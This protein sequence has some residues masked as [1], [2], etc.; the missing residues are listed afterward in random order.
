MHAQCKVIIHSLV[1]VLVAGLAGYL[2][3]EDF[4]AKVLLRFYRYKQV[5]E[6][7]SS[8]QRSFANTFIVYSSDFLLSSLSFGG[9][10]YPVAQSQITTPVLPLIWC[11]IH[12]SYFSFRGLIAM[13]TGGSD[14]AATS[15]SSEQFAFPMFLMDTIKRVEDSIDAKLSTIK[16]DLTLE[17]ES[18][19]DRAWARGLIPLGLEGVALEIIRVQRAVSLVDSLP[20]HWMYC[21]TS[22][23]KGESSLATVAG[24]EEC[25]NYAMIKLT[26]DNFTAHVHTRT[27]CLN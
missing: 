26:R 10:L 27:K 2:Y 21:I 23:G 13:A 11:G 19:D 4:E 25:N 1:V 12:S 14:P 8:Y 9:H 6:S 24:T 20:Q 15:G 3:A 18:A 7:F 22:A 16:R 17:R 5:Q